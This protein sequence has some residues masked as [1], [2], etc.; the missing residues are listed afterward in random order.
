MNQINRGG[1]WLL[2]VVHGIIPNLTTLTLIVSRQMMGNAV[3]F[4][5]ERGEK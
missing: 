4:V 3:C 2:T 1:K 5:M